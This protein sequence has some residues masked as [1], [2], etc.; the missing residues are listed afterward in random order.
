MAVIIPGI[1]DSMGFQWDWWFWKWGVKKILCLKKKGK[2]TCF[3][4]P[5]HIGCVAVVKK[6]Q[7]IRFIFHLSF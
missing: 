1:I 5:L 7:K 4:L 6:S 2:G 3:N